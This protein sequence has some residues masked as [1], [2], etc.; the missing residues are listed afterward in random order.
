M[1]TDNT[2]TRSCEEWVAAAA[3]KGRDEAVVE[4]VHR[5]FV[6][7]GPASVAHLA[8]WTNLTKTEIK[9]AITHLGDRLDSTALDGD[10]LWHDPNL[11]DP[12]T[13]DGAFL[14]QLFDE[15]YLTY[16]SSN[17]PRVAD[18]PYADQPLSLAEAGGGVVISDLRDVGSWKRK[19]IG[20]TTR[21]TLSLAKSL[22]ERRRVDIEAQAELLAAHTNRA[23]TLDFT[24]VRPV[25][26]M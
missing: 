3:T 9:A 11:L 19:D 7:H 25:T 12:G 23:L 24:Y 1:S 18:H 17:F 5:F 16:P 8:R 13:G 4:L 2:P 22:S 26:H 15:A 21:V 14:F 6:G 10:E 20:R